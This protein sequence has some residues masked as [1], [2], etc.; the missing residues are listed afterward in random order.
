MKQYGITSKR[1]L[2]DVGADWM[3]GPRKQKEFRRVDRKRARRQ[4]KEVVSMEV[5]EYEE[6]RL[7]MRSG[8]LVVGQQVFAL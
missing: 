5:D 3:I 2:G 7:S 1:Q 4:S 8:R 6:R